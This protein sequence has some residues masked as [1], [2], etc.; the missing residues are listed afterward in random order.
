MAA[1]FALAGVARYAALVASHV[2]VAVL[3]LSAALSFRAFVVGLAA[4]NAAHARA[5]GRVG[6]CR[7]GWPAVAVFALAGVVFV[8]LTV[9][10]VIL[11]VAGLFTRAQFA[12]FTRRDAVVAKGVR[13]R[14]TALRGLFCNADGLA[15]GGNGLA[16]V[17]GRTVT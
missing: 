4:R 9:A 11:A 5:D 6:A 7:T 17:L 16:R 15:K 13:T 1:N 12:C 2:A 8:D 14:R 10:V 3:E